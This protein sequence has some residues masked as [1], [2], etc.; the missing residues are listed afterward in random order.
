MD[1][2]FSVGGVPI[3]LTSE[4]WLHIVE[5]HDDLAGY[6]D[7]VLAAVED[8]EMVLRGYRGALIAIRNYGHRRYLLVVYRQLSAD[9]GFILTAFFS[10]EIDRYK[11]I[12]K[13]P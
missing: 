10:T 6:Y 5:T 13:R 7:D 2:A 9:D 8:P 1:I 11:V 12:W 3:R 4:R